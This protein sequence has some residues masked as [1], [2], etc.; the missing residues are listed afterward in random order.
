MYNVI[1]VVGSPD[2]GALAVRE[3]EKREHAS[4]H[5]PRGGAVR[6]GG[7]CFSR[8]E[9]KQC[10]KTQKTKRK[11]KIQKT[12]ACVTSRTFRHARFPRARAH[13]PR[14]FVKSSL[15]CPLSTRAARTRRRGC[16]FVPFYRA[17]RATHRYFILIV[18][19]ARTGE[20]KSQNAGRKWE[21]RKSG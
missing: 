5:S 11:P 19:P 17:V 2:G 12:T 7:F 10:R 21:R 9:Q 6:A 16:F 20:R 15:L 8:N 3:V 18:P 14:T 4:T 13:R 1:V